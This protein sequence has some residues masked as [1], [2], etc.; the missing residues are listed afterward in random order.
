MNR[1]TRRLLAFIAFTISTTLLLS[2][3]ESTTSQPQEPTSGPY[4]VGDYYNE[5]GLEGVVFQVSED[6]TSGKIVHL[7]Q[8]RGV[9]MWASSK[10]GANRLFG[11]TNMSDGAANCRIITQ[12]YGWKEKFP[13]FAWCIALGKGWYL[14]AIDELYEFTMNSATQRLVNTTLKK[15]G[16][17]P[18]P[19]RSEWVD[20][21]SST[22]MDLRYAN[23]EYSA[24]GINTQNG[25]MKD[26]RHLYARVRAVA[27]F[28]IV[29][30]E[31]A[32]DSA[33]NI[34][35]APY[36]VGDYYNDGTLQGVVFEVSEGGMHGK[37]ISMSQPSQDLLW[38]IGEEQKR[39]IGATDRKSGKTNMVK[40]MSIEGWQKLYPAFAWCAS[41]GEGW[42]LPAIEEVKVFMS[43]D[44]H[45]KVNATLDSQLATKLH[46]LHPVPPAEK[47]EDYWSST[48]SEELYTPDEEYEG[49]V[50]A[51]AIG[52]FI[53]NSTEYQATK[54]ND[55][56][57]RA[58][59]E[60]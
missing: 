42:Y 17:T 58:V 36:N 21:W 14:P 11:A 37:I 20:Y 47:W 8:S 3:Q 52:Y 35:S 10:E 43:E 6:G 15:L 24:W 9:R 56:S 31:A 5:G 25:V 7:T 34:T 19:N 44:V 59:A 28:P 55:S 2:A 45:A 26:A 30:V 18:I 29:E 54:R 1:F 27:A 40:V 13:A 51:Y 46:T 60:F 57:V 39:V 4:K 53:I 16:A 23:G 48:E 12:L 50:C 38:S 33:A 22:E 41:L 49:D 32:N